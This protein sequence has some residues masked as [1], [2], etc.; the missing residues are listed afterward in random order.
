MTFLIYPFSYR[1]LTIDTQKSKSI[2]TCW[3]GEEFISS[4]AVAKKR[5]ERKRQWILTAVFQGGWGFSEDDSIQIFLLP[6][7]LMLVLDSCER[8]VNILMKIRTRDIFAFYFPFFLEFF[9][10]VQPNFLQT[11]SCIECFLQET[12]Y[13][14]AVTKTGPVCA[15]ISFHSGFFLSL[16]RFFHPSFVCGSNTFFPTLRTAK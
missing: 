1:Y 11:R 9:A 12:F 14:A 15:E 6:F 2:P 3:S 13:I 5:R 4:T 10:V 8:F 16:H 7:K